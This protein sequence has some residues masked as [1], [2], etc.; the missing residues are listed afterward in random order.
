MKSEILSFHTYFI[1]N[2]A[3]MLS[4][5]LAR[6]IMAIPIIDK[7]LEQ[8][9]KLKFARY[10]LLITMLIFLLIPHFAHLYPTPQIQDESQPVFQHVLLILN[11]SQTIVETQISSVKNMSLSIPF[12]KIAICIWIT[13]IF[14][15]L[16]RYITTLFSLYKLSQTS[17]Y[18][19]H[20][21]NIRILLTTQSCVP[22][23][24][25]LFHNHFVILPVKI[26]ESSIDTKLSIRH[27]LQHIRQGDTQW[28]HFMQILNIFFF[29][30]PFL[31]LWKKWFAQL[32]EF[33]C[34][35]RVILHKQTPATQYAQCLINAARDAHTA[36]NPLAMALFR[37]DLS[38]SLLYRRVNMLFI[39]KTQKRKWVLFTAYA[40]SICAISS[41]ALALNGV[42]PSTATTARTITSIIKKHDLNSTFHI[43]ATP[44]VVAEV[45]RVRLNE[46]ARTKMIAAL[47]RMNQYKPDIEA[48]LAN[49][50]MP[51]DLLA[52]PL[53]ESGYKP[54]D[55]SVNPMRAAGIWQIIPSTAVRLG[56]VVEKNR[57]DRMDMKL[58]T[59]AA[60]TYLN[61]LHK[62]FND[63]KLAVIAYEIGENETARLIK[64]IGSRDAWT[65]AYSDKI[66][67]KYKNELKKYLAMF[68]ASVIIINDPKIISG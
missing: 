37:H 48:A 54:L 22:L 3:I 10:C 16:F 56:L 11:Q 4:F 53:V 8:I 36:E 31:L 67:N 49:Q 7:Q 23:C 33:A 50:S 15:C 59:Q 29:W 32:Q 21:K 19:R 40:V 60:L 18:Q 34:D 13:G 66:P 28:L 2:A 24:W 25:S 26:L 68:D 58:A 45:N 27:E 55:E 30:N 62:Q 44:E 20:I 63:W 47:D 46:H 51:T 14:I 57:D 61:A 35:E 5:L 64:L 6:F 17:F 42:S 52:L 65:I 9:Q 1:A 41:A 39:Y 12:K 43:Q 38:P